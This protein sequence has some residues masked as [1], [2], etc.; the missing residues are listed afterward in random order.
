MDMAGCSLPGYI[1][2]NGKSRGPWRESDYGKLD[3]LATVQKML[4]EA[5][6]F[7]LEG[8]TFELTDGAGN[9]QPIIVKNVWQSPITVQHNPNDM[10][11]PEAAG[12]KPIPQ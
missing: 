3:K 11:L 6:P 8:V 4:K 7:Q 10:V 1:K 5:D 2:D 9:V 12:S